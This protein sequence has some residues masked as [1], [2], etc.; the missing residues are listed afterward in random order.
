M[1]SIAFSVNS[2]PVTLDVR[3]SETLGEVLRYRL[4]LTGTKIGCN[5]AE[6][7]ICTVLVTRPGADRG[8]P[9]DSCVYPALK[10]AGCKVLTIEG[11]AAEWR[12]E[13]SNLKSQISKSGLHPLQEAFVA[14]GAAQCGF[15]IPGL[16]MT[17]KALLD[18]NPDP[19]NDEIKSA[20]KD[21]YCRCEG[22][23]HILSAIREAA[24]VMREG[25]PLRPM[26]LPET[27]HGLR[28]VGEA[29]PRP[30]A[31]A[32]VTGAAKYTDDYG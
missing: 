2:Q 24:R 31:V 15:C 8:T 30:E 19:T 25:G 26:P 18:S 32:K 17:A 9:V 12:G 7:G 10:A 4:G 3:D 11:L 14:H 6:C 29:V 5:E 21:T 27:K 1:T 22:F 20:L 13:I 23:S 28:V 16:I